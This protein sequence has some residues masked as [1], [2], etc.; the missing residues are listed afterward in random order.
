[1]HAAIEAV[2]GDA[3]TALDVLETGFDDATA[4]LP[5]PLKYRRRL[6]STNMSSV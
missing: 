1:L 4:V 2:D 5:L 3:E 6:R